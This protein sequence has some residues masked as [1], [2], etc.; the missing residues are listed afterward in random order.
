[1]PEEVKSTVRFMAL[2]DDMHL[3]RPEMAIAPAQLL[4][5]LEGD[6]LFIGD[7]ALRYRDLI[8][9]RCGNCAHFVTDDLNQPKASAGAALALS[10]LKSGQTVSPLELAPCYLRLP[11]AQLSK[12]P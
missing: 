5:E 12:K 11:E 8:V 1:M 7:G 3:I 4:D 6:V 10:R 2:M 9:E